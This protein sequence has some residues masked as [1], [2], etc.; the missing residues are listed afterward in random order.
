MLSTMQGDGPLSPALL[1]EPRDFKGQILEYWPDL[2]HA[3]K[4]W[5]GKSQVLSHGCIRYKMGCV[6][7]AG[8]MKL[9]PCVCSDP[10]SSTGYCH[11]F[12]NLSSYCGSPQGFVT[13]LLLKKGKEHG[14]G[15]CFLSLKSSDVGR[16]EN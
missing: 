11:L 6:L 1:P 10:W 7:Q 12:E 15:L 8:K 16:G 13:R 4:G 3:G 5:G 2:S 9:N 14:I